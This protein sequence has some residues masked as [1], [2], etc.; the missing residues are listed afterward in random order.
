[1][2]NADDDSQTDAYINVYNPVDENAKTAVI[3]DN[4]NPIFFQAIDVTVEF[5]TLGTAPPVVF[6]LWDR[7]ESLIEA[8]DKDDYL[9]CTNIKLTDA[10]LVVQG[11]DDKNQF[12]N[13]TN[14]VFTEDSSELNKIPKPKWHDIRFG[15]KE[16]L[17]VT[18]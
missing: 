14:V 6:K 9:G 17:P 10:N 2:P 5:D 3:M 11:R 18:G 13:Y 1:M 8:F 4:L 15:Y 12:R 7:D 16:T